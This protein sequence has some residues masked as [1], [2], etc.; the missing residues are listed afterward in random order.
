MSVEDI[1]LNQSVESDIED[2]PSDFNNSD[3]QWYEIDEHTILSSDS[4]DDDM[5]I[6]LYDELWTS[7]FSVKQNAVDNLPTILQR[8]GHPTLPSTARILFNTVKHVEIDNKSGMEYVYLGVEDQ[9]RKHLIK[10]AKTV[11]D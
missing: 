7:K 10:C 1:I 3:L 5:V 11:R 2:A 6:T 8:S 9:I 4:E